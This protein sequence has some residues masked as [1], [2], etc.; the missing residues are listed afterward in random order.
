MTVKELRNIKSKQYLKCVVFTT[1]NVVYL[2]YARML[3]LISRKIKF[4]EEQGF[5]LLKKL[6]I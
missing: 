3:S 5:E 4:S 1:L 6:W 2:I